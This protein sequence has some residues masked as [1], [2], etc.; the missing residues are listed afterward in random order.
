MAW[1]EPVTDRV[2]GAYMTAGDCNRITGNLRALDGNAALPANVSEDTI[3]T[4]WM[5]KVL[6]VLR[7]L[8]LTLG[9]PVGALDGAWTY[10]NINHIETLILACKDKVDLLQRQ[11]ALTVYA[12]DGY[13]GQG[14]YYVGGF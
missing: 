11:T 9:V 13:C 1:V 2:G 6:T 12:G 5:D 7:G 3:L 14:D 4:D 10:S 8:C